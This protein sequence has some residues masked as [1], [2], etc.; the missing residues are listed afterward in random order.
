MYRNSLLINF[1]S[2]DEMNTKSLNSN[3][4]LLA[5]ILGV[6]VIATVGT[7]LAFAQTAGTTS[8]TT[9][10][11]TPPKIQGSVNLQQMLLSSVQTKFA[12]AANTAAGAVT[13]GQVIG[14][15]LTVIQGSVI[16]SFKVFDGTNI[17]SV[18]VDAGNGKVLNTSQ[19]NP[20]QLGEL[21]GGGHGMRGHHMGGNAW[22]SHQPSTTTPSTTIPSTGTQ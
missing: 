8:G 19:G 20:M 3:T 13:N 17:Y 21:L 10:T 1:S 6:A 16:Y 18:I 15:S 5:M 4:K 22:K 14:G 2:N 7:S 11:T 9:S 12:D